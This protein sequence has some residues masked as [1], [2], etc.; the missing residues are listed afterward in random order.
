MH[1][2]SI[3]FFPLALFSFSG[4]LSGC[5]SSQKD[6]A[7]I[8]SAGDKATVGSLVY[9]LVD[10]ERSQQLGD[11]GAAART[12]KDRFYVLKISVSNSGADESPIPAMTLIDD[13]GESYNELVDGTGV[14]NWL[15]V[16]R[17]VGGAQTETGDVVF[18]APLKHFR[19]RINDS[20]DEKEISIDIPLSFVHDS[21]RTPASAPSL[22]PSSP[23]PADTPLQLPQK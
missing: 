3:A 4:G 18:D 10:A 20:L 2:I 5:G 11:D 9:N 19:L 15:G 12:A 23:S 14:S 1:Y 6:K 21:N 16:V 8:Y 13:S 17:K 7:T 22:T